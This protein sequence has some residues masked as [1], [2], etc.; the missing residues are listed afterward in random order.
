MK[1]ISFNPFPVL[2]TERLTLRQLSIDDDKEIFLL[3]SDMEA[4]KY[5]DRDPCG[6]IE[7][8][9]KFIQKITEFVD[10]NNGIYW[11]ITLENNNL[12]GTICMF[13]FSYEIS[14]AE[15]GYELLPTFQGQGIMHEAI[16]KV[17]EYG[18]HNI[19]L[20]SIEGFTHIENLPS[21]KL[22]EKCNF[23]KQEEKDSNSN[24]LFVLY[25]L[26]TI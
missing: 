15:I 20:K 25:K 26:S 4:N 10:Q 16:T 8:A 9:R 5:I 22:L 2:K 3:R 24:E 23:K 18:I 13:N 17:I 19:G 12:V 6:T 7:E 14:Q 11:A 1:S 21:S